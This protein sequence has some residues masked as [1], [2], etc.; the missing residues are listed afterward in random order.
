[1]D[2]TP[3][4]ETHNEIQDLIMSIISSL[5]PNTRNIKKEAL[6]KSLDQHLFMKCDTQFRNKMKVAVNE[7]YNSFCH[8]EASTSAKSTPTGVSALHSLTSLSKPATVI[9]NVLPLKR[10]P[11]E[12]TNQISMSIDDLIGESV[13]SVDIE[14]QSLKRQKPS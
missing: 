2:T 10:K 9:N 1:M 7:I 5:K 12:E 14:N 8:N 4:K 13:C 6:L 3:N 11:E